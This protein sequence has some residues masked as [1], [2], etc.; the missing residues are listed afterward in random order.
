MDQF[1]EVVRCAVDDGPQTIDL[2]DRETVV[3][4]SKT[5]FDQLGNFKGGNLKDALMA[6]NLEGVDLRRDST[7]PRDAGI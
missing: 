3:V 4:M 2:V 1:A 5:Q 6:L 7:S